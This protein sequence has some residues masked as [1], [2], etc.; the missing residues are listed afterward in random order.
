MVGLPFADA[1]FHAYV[2]ILLLCT[3]TGGAAAAS[4]AHQASVQNV[5][6]ALVRSTNLPRFQPFLDYSVNSK[7]TSR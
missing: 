7:W 4:L 6:Y 3:V 2:F 5:R 1:A